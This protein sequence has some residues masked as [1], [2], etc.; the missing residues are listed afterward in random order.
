MCAQTGIPIIAPI[1]Q[2]MYVC[3]MDASVCV[4]TCA[5]TKSLGIVRETRKTWKDIFMTNAVI[6]CVN[7]MSSVF[8]STQVSRNGKSIYLVS[9][10]MRIVLYLCNN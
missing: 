7:K 1:A 5:Y 8:F 4:C 10:T 9:D 3:A 6:S 2:N